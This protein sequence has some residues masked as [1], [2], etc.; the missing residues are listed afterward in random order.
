VAVH[1]FVAG[2][3]VAPLWQLSREHLRILVSTLD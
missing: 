3:A 1:R 2:E